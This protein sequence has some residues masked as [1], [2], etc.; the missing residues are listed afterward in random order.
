MAESGIKHIAHDFDDT[1]FLT[2]RHFHDRIAGTAEYLDRFLKAG[3][4]EL[5]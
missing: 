1:F 4:V 3:Q 2:S 5:R